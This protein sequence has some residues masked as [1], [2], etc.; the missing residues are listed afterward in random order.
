MGGLLLYLSLLLSFTGDQTVFL[1]ESLIFVIL[2]Q[3]KYIH[4]HFI[5]NNFDTISA[6]TNIRMI[7]TAI[8]FEYKGG[9]IV[10]P[11]ITDYIDDVPLLRERQKNKGVT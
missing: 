2:Q 8:D 10:S 4:L 6:I 3:L 1:C 11:P 7:M 5:T 9:G